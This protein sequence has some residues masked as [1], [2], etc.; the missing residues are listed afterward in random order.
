MSLLK[1]NR[2]FEKENRK[3]HTIVKLLRDELIEGRNFEK[4]DYLA[5]V[6]DSLTIKESL[7]KEREPILIRDKTKRWLSKQNIV[8]LPWL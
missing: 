3:L 7:K 4:L 1:K 2:V 8:D 5:R 6:A